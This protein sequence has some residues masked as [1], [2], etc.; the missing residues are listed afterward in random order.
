MATIRFK[1]ILTFVTHGLVTIF[2]MFFKHFGAISFILE[3]TSYGK[4]DAQKRATFLSISCK[5]AA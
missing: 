5:T 3:G 1:T 2:L 4:N